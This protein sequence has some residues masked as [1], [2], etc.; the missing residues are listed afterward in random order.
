VAG[1]A[2]WAV[3]AALALAGCASASNG[4]AAGSGAERGR[5]IAARA[6]GGCHGLGDV[7]DSPRVGAPPFRE[8][9]LRYNALSFE[10]RMVEIAEGGHYDMPPLRLE[11]GDV[12][13]VQAYIESFASP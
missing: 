1:R 6:C 12:A 5:A 11:P 4:V 13:D 3:A 10:R 9:R 2:G 7:G 8:L